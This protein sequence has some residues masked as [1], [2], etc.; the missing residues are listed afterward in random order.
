M[1]R[2]KHKTN[3]ATTH[4]L[5]TELLNRP[6]GFLTATHEER[7]LIISN[8]QRVSTYANSDDSVT[9]W[10]LNLRDVGNGNIKR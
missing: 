5:A 4:M 9:Y 1:N 10:T 7:E 3:Y 2:R 8:I 6:N